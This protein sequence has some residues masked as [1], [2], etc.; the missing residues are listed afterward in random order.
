V[1]N[2][3]GS[4]SFAPSH[5]RFHQNQ[6]SWS[7]SPLGSK[8]P[9]WL[10]R[11]IKNQPSCWVLKQHRVKPGSLEQKRLLE[12]NAVESNFCLRGE[13]ALKRQKQASV[14]LQSWS[15]GDQVGL[16]DVGVVVFIRGYELLM[17]SGGGE[18]GMAVTRTLVN[19]LQIESQVSEFCCAKRPRLMLFDVQNFPAEGESSLSRELL[20]LAAQK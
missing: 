13:T 3:K 2:Y 16:L 20:L 1:I 14:P 10:S 11:L 9:K 19:P 18:R 17:C 6:K 5:L 8:R 15:V 4:G 12:I 7:K